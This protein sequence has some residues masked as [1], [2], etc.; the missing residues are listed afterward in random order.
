MRSEPPLE[1][2]PS[3]WDEPEEDSAPE[4][5]LDRF[6]KKGRKTMLIIDRGKYVRERRQLIFD[7]AFDGCDCVYRDIMKNVLCINCPVH[8]CFYEC[9]RMTVDSYEGLLRPI[10]DDFSNKGEER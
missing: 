8:S 10:P 9:L 3:Y 1:P 2:P 6:L 7:R 4:S 5:W